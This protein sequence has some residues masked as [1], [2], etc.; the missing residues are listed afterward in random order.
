[1]IPPLSYHT[2]RTYW[3]HK[4]FKKGVWNVTLICWVKPKSTNTCFLFSQH[5]RFNS[6]LVP[7]DSEGCRRM[8]RNSVPQCVVL[9][10]VFYVT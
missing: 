5:V 10:L 2:I 1:M 9:S 8:L 3:S 6:Y 4:I 7:F